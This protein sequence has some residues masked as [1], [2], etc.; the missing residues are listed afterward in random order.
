MVHIFSAHFYTKLTEDPPP[1]ERFGLSAW[2]LPRTADILTKLSCCVT[3]LKAA[4]KGAKKKGAAAAS[5][6]I[7]DEEDE[8]DLLTPFHELIKNIPKHNPFEVRKC[9]PI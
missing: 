6:D 3:E 9:R 4:K 7:A 1:G 5:S 8:S 2:R